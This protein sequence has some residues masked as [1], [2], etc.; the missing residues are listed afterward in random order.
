M[1]S[2]FKN[3]K[4]KFQKR[5]LFGVTCRRRM[6]WYTGNPMPSKW[7]VKLYKSWL[8]LKRSGIGKND[9]V[10]SRSKEVEKERHLRYCLLYFVS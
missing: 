6:T 4:R 10:R 5:G 1:R 3:L 9:R 7:R 8:F 2:D